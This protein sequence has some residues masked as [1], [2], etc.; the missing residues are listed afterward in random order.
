[1]AKDETGILKNLEDV[2]NFYRL[3]AGVTPSE[4]R[5]QMVG[6]VYMIGGD[7]KRNPYR[8]E[9]ILQIDGKY[10]RYHKVLLITLGKRVKP[11][12]FELGVYCVLKSLEDA[13][14]RLVEPTQAEIALFNAKPPGRLIDA[15]EWIK[16]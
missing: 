5:K 12:E 1:M 15:L 4:L 8:V 11:V 6:E 16:E 13:A 9:D 14:R 2:R 3:E 10:C 7:L